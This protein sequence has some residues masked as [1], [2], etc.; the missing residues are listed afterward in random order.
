MREEKKFRRENHSNITMQSAKGEKQNKDPFQDV[1]TLCW[2]FRTTSRVFPFQ[3]PP[4]LF[5]C[6]WLSLPRLYIKVWGTPPSSNK[7]LRTSKMPWIIERNGALDIFLLLRNSKS[8]FVTR[9]ACFPI[10]TRESPSGDTSNVGVSL[11]GVVSRVVW[12]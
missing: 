5:L 3:F 8:V 11:F 1:E 7:E 2:T 4:P 12:Y 6:S 10:I 9:G